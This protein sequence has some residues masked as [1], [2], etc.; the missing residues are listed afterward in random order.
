ML[1]QNEV[2]RGDLH[3]YKIKLNRM[4]IRKGA[5]VMYARGL[6]SER[7]LKEI[8]YSAKRADLTYF[9]PLLCV[10]SKLEAVPYYKRVEIEKQASPLSYEYILAD[11]P[12]S[13][14]DVI[15]MG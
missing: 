7:D 12:P 2:N 13:A 10:I 9:R 5:Q 6:I 4:G 11:L 8:T 3:S 15:R 14:F 1:L